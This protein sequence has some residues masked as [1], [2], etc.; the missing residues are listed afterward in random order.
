MAHS[1]NHPLLLKKKEERQL[2]RELLLFY[3]VTSLYLAAGFDLSLAWT[4]GMRRSSPQLKDQ[5]RETQSQETLLENLTRLENFFVISRYRF[6]FSLLKQLYLQGSPL[7][8]AFKSF[9]RFLRTELERDL[10]AHLRVTPT[11][12]NLI[13]IAFFLPATL[14]L[15]FVPFLM[16][17]SLVFLGAE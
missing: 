6:T 7:A 12:V 2:R 5:L 4:E 13:Q 15:L 8:P 17:L 10:E 3:E 14:A 9:S 16:H 11:R 1:K